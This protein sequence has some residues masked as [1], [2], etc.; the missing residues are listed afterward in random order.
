MYNAMIVSDLPVFDNKKNWK[1]KIQLKKKNLHGIYVG[2]YS[3]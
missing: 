3:Y 2:G 1:M